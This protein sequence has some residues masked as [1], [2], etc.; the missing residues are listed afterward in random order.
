MPSWIQT[1]LIIVTCYGL[2]HSLLTTK[3]A[4]K[5]FNSIFPEYLWNIIYS[6]ISVTTLVAGFHFWESSGVYLFYLQPGSLLFHLSVITLAASLFFFFF[7][8]KYTTSF[9]QWLGVKQVATK[10]AGKKMPAYYRVRQNGIKR[11]I[12]FPHHLCLV[13]LFWTHPVMTLDTLFLAVAATVYL[14]IGT[15]HQDLRGLR[16]IGPEWAAYRQETNLLFPA[17]KAFRR[18]FQDIRAAR[19]DSEEVSP[20]DSSAVASIETGGT[21]AKPSAKKFV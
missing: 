8:F 18:L 13:I 11:Y 10:L 17:G 20:H 15:Y 6:A 7:C 5:I 1:D 19:G 14:Y 21:D 9:W 4:V 3:T 16:I 2:Q 12:R